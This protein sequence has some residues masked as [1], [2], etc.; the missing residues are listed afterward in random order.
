MFTIDKDKTNLLKAIGIMMVLLGHGTSWLTDSKCYLFKW[1]GAIGV[2]IF[3]FI[4]GYG[5]CESYISHGRAIRPVEWWK[6]RITKV[7][8][9]FWIMMAIETVYIYLFTEHT[10]TRREWLIAFIGY[11]DY[12]SSI[13][14]D[15]T[16][17]Y[18]TFLIM[19]Y[20]VF[21][22]IFIIKPLPDYIKLLIL[23]AFT[24]IGYNMHF[25]LVDDWNM[26]YF[27]FALGVTVSVLSKYL[28]KIPEALVKYISLISALVLICI[29]SG[30]FNDKMIGNSLFHTYEYSA[31]IMFLGIVHYIKANSNKA[32]VCY[33]V[34]S[35]L[36]DTSYFIYLTE[37]FII[38]RIA[39][40]FI[41]ELRYSNL[42]Y[43]WGLAIVSGI[44]MYYIFECFSQLISRNRE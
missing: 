33:K 35:I 36:G 23:W 16:M 27:S 31:L 13:T 38:Q 7:M 42:V 4:S 11:V 25:A 15:S 39:F 1:A 19:W 21:F 34:F 37:G 32:G 10:I 12:D 41:N 8:F 17:W 29:S 30:Y 40:I 20:L 14:I 44:L 22:L 5:L 2:C 9:P 28:R 6:K 3:L 18:I 43:F 26:N 24:I